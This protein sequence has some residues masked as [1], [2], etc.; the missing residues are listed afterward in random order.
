MGL[1]FFTSALGVAHN[2]VLEM[3]F[4]ANATPA[5]ALP[6][7]LGGFTMMLLLLLT[8]RILGRI[9]PRTA[10]LNESHMGAVLDC[11]L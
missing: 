7:S 9:E 4:G 1:G 3:R 8:W 11:N 5:D 6:A 10:D 2:A